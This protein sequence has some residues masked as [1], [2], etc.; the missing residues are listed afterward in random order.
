MRRDAVLATALA[1]V[2]LGASPAFARLFV[3][4]AWRGRYLAAGLLAIAVAALVREVRGGVVA[5]ALS[6]VGALVMFTYVTALPHVGLF[7]GATSW[8]SFVD[9]LAE[10]FD[11][12]RGETA[13]TV[14][15][16]PFV[17]LIATGT[18]LVAHLA[19]EITVR[20]RRPGLGLVPLLV[21]WAVPL[22]F[23]VEGEDG[24]T[25]LRALPFLAAAGLV[26]L[27]G[28]DHGDQDDRP[29][30]SVSGLTV[31][32]AALALTA[33]APL[34]LPGY[35]ATAWVDLSGGSDPRGYQPIVDVS[36][37]LK[38][39]TERDVLRI[40][41]SERTYLRLA[42]L[43]SFDGA[44]WRLGPAGVGSYQPAESSLHRADRELPPEERADA[45]VRTRVEVEVLDLANIYVP[46]PYQPTRVEGPLNREMVWSTEGGFLATWNVTEDGGLGGEPRVG[47]SEGVT[48]AVEAERPA[49]LLEDLRE[50]SY[51]PQTLARWTELP[52]EYARLAEA[53]EA[54]YEAAGATTNADRALALQDWFTSGGGF[55]YDLDVDPLRGADA[56]ET[57]VLE[58]R[59]GYCEY[60]ATAMAVMLRA[61]DVPARV[62]VGFLP[63]TVTEAADPEAGDPLTEYT[64]TTAD[65][66]AWVEVLFPDYGWVTFEPTPRSDQTQLVPTAEDLAPVENLREQRARELRELAEET[67]QV[68]T[69]E[70]P[71]PVPAP[72]PDAATDGTTGDDPD[73][74]AA[75]PGWWPWVAGLLLALGA[76]LAVAASRRRGA[77]V[78]SA[79]RV[80]VLAAQ[81]SL[82]GAGARYGV[83]R[84]EHET[85]HELLHR[86]HTEGRVSS[87]GTRFATLAT[88]AAFGGDIDDEVAHEAERL[89]ADLEAQLRA[90]VPTGDRVL[91]PVRVPLEA[92]TAGLRRAGTAVASRLRR[93]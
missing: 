92:T 77:P 31:G 44:T 28:T 33:V 71:D 15:A 27:L 72:T 54:V 58:D 65:A 39:P 12:L 10:A 29:R 13:P 18:W 69:P 49:P 16:A 64:V 70:T 35:G 87:D 68:E 8:G 83:G 26:L 41:A 75:T 20:W 22:A 53:A 45:T 38:L 78:G 56:L 57:F 67:D 62:A 2:V 14:S 32:A 37:R 47:V 88:A 7:P 19:H 79:P 24:G 21:L 85:T 43:D 5:A 17:L 90:S 23:P 3:D 74:G 66:H 82:L 6:S 42:G 11:G 34:L 36:E 48:Y 61:T 60:F 84:A 51:T 25:F 89:V 63:G 1:V 59:I 4:D 9:L 76:A 81:R 46:A 50:V 52:S 30:A 40:R 73:A 55:T 80:R 86:W 93:P 91:S